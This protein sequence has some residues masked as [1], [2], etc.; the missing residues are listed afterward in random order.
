MMET[1]ASICL[2]STPLKL[3]GFSA[4]IDFDDFN[5]RCTV[6]LFN[7]SLICSSRLWQC[8]TVSAVFNF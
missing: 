4:A 6:L 1:I 2:N 5:R 8:S 7:S 3:K